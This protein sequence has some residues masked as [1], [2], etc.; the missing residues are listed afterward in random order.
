MLT[1]AS[2]H[3]FCQHPLCFFAALTFLLQID[4]NTLQR[5]CSVQSYDF[6]SDKHSFLKKK[7]S[8]AVL[9]FRKDVLLATFSTQ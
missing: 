8:I 9:F 6:Y 7:T 3:L 1:E 4:K 5:P 2:P